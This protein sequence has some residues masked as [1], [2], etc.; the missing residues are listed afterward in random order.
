MRSVHRMQFPVIGSL[1]RHGACVRLLSVLHAHTSQR[2]MSGEDSV[3]NIA[4]IP[5]RQAHSATC[6]G[7]RTLTAEQMSARGA[8]LLAS[9]VRNTQRRRPCRYRLMNLILQLQMRF[10]ASTMA[11]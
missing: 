1:A 11:A 5:D 10:N 2:Q 9:S 6:T 4:K 7:T 8:A 3:R